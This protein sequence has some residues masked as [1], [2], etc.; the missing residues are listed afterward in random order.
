V[1][2]HTTR[3]VVWTVVCTFDYFSA[4]NA[5]IGTAGGATVGSPF[6]GFF[7][8]SAANYSLNKL[9]VDAGAGIEFGSK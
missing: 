8:G 1:T 4:S 7:S 5:A 6:L 9:G 2:V 3:F